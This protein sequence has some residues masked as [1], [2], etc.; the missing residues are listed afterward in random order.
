MRWRDESITERWLQE[1]HDDVEE[2]LERLERLEQPRFSD[3]LP[4][5]LLTSSGPAAWLLASKRE[6]KESHDG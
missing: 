5:L 3:I 2:E 1:L 4:M 6:K